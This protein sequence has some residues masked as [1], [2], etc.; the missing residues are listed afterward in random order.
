MP[1]SDKLSTERTVVVTGGVEGIGRAIAD[2][3]LRNGNRVAI[4]DKNKSAGA[5]MQRGNPNVYF[6][7]ADLSDPAV[8]K[9]LIDKINDEFGRL[10]ILVNNAGFQYVSP[11]EDF[12]DDISEKMF[13]LMLR[14]PFLLSKYAMPIMKKNHWGRIINIASIHG[15]VASPLKAAY[16]T[17]K[18]GLI[19]LTKAVALESITSG[20]T[21]NAVAPTY[22][23]TSLVTNQ[24]KAQAEHLHVDESR[25]ISDVLM[26]DSPVARLLEP[27]EVASMVMYLASDA[28][29]AINGSVLTIDHGYTSR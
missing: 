17:V 25:V 12:P 21:C 22:V 8:C 20:I 6:W 24:I 11:F 16:V 27:E 29:S 10:D 1:F 4:L 19:G 26:K 13:D 15:M 14:T 28:A 9:T 18:H 2:S 7:E 3:F 23:K 5:E